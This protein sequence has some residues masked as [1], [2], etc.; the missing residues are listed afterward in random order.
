MSIAASM[1]LLSRVMDVVAEVANEA[2]A[3][4][5]LWVD[6]LDDM[7]KL[8]FM[9]IFILI[10][11]MLI[12]VRARRRKVQPAKGRSFLSSVVLVMLFSFG[13]GWMIDSRFEMQDVLNFF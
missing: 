2:Y 1:D 6:R 7:E 5:M 12:L 13:A 10:L 8:F 11:F 3:D 9:V 4:F